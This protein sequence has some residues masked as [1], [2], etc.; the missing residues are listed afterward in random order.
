MTLSNNTNRDNLN[1]ELRSRLN[2]KNWSASTASDVYTKIKHRRNNRI[3]R[4]LSGAAA[5]AASILL[6]FIF[7]AGDSEP[8]VGSF[9]SFIADQTIQTYL[10]AAE[11]NDIVESDIEFSDELFSNETDL[12]I[13]EALASR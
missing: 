5:A 13:S 10:K 1:R 6:V 3:K 9:E 12:L 2:D 11:I 7:I 8:D 4:T